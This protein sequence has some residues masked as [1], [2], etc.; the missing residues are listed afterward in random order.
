VIDPA[1]VY[2]GFWQYEGGGLYYGV[3][4]S[5]YLCWLAGGLASSVLVEAAVSYFKPLLPPP[6]QVGSSAFFILFFWTAI[7][8]FGGLGIPAAIG[9]A[10]ALAMYLWYRRSYY[11]FDDMVVLVDDEN[12]ALATARKAETHNADTKLHR[13]FS[14]FLFNSN[15]ELLLQRRAFSKKTWPGTWSNSCCGH[16]MLNEGTKQAAGRRL[17]FELG[18]RGVELNMVLPDFRYRAEKDGVVENEICPVMIGFTDQEPTPNPGEV[19]ETKWMHWSDFL[20]YIRRPDCE[21]SPWAIEEGHLLDQ[22]GVLRGRFDEDDLAA[23]A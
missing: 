7:A 16:T 11:A 18:I 21:L 19:A 15:G 20:S 13:A 1:A 23:A 8:A 22:S 3:P 12:N 5:N 6:V 9:G 10:G 14:V 4:L 2:L 17:A